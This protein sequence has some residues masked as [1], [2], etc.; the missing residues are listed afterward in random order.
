MK[1][2]SLFHCAKKWKKWFNSFDKIDDTF[3][4]IDCNY[5][6]PAPALSCLPPAACCAFLCLLL[7]KFFYIKCETLTSPPPNFSLIQCCKKCLFIFEYKKN[8]NK[9]FQ[10]QC[11]P[12]RMFSL[13]K[14]WAYHI[15]WERDSHRPLFFQTRF[16]NIH[17]GNFFWL[18][19]LLQLAA[20]DPDLKSLSL[21]MG[22]SFPTTTTTHEDP[23]PCHLTC[24]WVG[25]R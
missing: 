2:N 7:K 20:I 25:G 15:I 21:G 5:R 11:I 19:K 9:N 8:V 13:F 10:N 18:K 14:I 1:K 12:V 23:D 24:K 3:T 16:L 17:F 4:G 6:S 22:K